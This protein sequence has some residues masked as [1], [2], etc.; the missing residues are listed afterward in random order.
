MN[1]LGLVFV[2]ENLIVFVLLILIFKLDDRFLNIYD[3][4]FYL[5][6]WYFNNIVM[7]ILVLF[8]NF[9]K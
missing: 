4:R 6:V 7:K 2:F 8:G 5:G 3:L 9:Y 1:L